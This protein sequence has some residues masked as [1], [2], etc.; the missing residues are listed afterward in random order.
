MDK[1][2]KTYSTKKNSALCIYVPCVGKGRRKVR[3]ALDGLTCGASRGA[4]VSFQ[5]EDADH[6]R[7]HPWACHMAPRLTALTPGFKPAGLAARK[8]AELP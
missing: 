5:S 7:T 1:I 2:E 3:R 4:P 6:A 8:T